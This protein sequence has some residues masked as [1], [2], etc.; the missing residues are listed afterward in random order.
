LATNT[1]EGWFMAE[2]HIVFGPQGAGKSSYSRT[3][4]TASEG[5]R[6]SIDEWMAQLYGPDLPDS[7]NL[8]WIMER[9]QRCERQIWRIAEQIAKNGGNVVLDLGFMKVRNRS[10]F[11]EQ[12]RAAG[13]SSKLHYVTAPHDIRRSRVMR[14]NSEKGETFSFE[15]SPAMFDF[16]EAEFEAP[17]QIEL[18]SATVFNSHIVAS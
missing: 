3:L 4:A 1:E 10:A 6:F 16:M 5:T 2:I 17:T 15:V 8:S 7:I 18:A 11:S 13:I 12:A 14:R 9:V